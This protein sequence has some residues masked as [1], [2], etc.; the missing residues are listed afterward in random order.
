M[1]PGAGGGPQHPGRRRG[2]APH[3]G[4]AQCGRG[5]REV[6]GHQVP[7]PEALRPRRC[8][9]A[10]PDP[11]RPAPGS[12]RP[13][14]GLRLPRH[15][16]PRPPQRAGQ[17]R[18]QVARPAVPGVRGLR[19]PRLD[20]GLRRRQVPPGPGGHLR[21]PQRRRAPGQPG[22]QPV[23]PRGGRPGGRGHDPSPHGRDPP[24]PDPAVPGAADPHAR[25]RRVRRTGRRGRDAEPQPDQG[26]PRRRHH[27]RDREQPARL[28]HP[29]GVRTQLRVLHR[30]R[31]GGAGPDHP[32]QRRRPRGLR[33]GGPTGLRLSAA[34]PQGRG[35]RHGVLPPPRPQRG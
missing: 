13:G 14:H 16:A 31:Q 22:R 18:R 6:P 29:S 9:V 2:P 33:P 17:H 5:P 23:A 25:R 11:R 27:P 10:H 24:R 1:D 21:Q 15:A 19:R 30:H 35:D 4:T 32:R 26:L 7:R 34:V 12:R 20:P 8:R 3:P 28:H